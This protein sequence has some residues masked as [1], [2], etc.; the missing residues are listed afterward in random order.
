[1]IKREKKTESSHSAR[2]EERAKEWY[3]IGKENLFI[4][5]NKDPFSF[6]FN[7]LHLFLTASITLIVK[8]QSESP[9]HGA[10]FVMF[11]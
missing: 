8:E 9:P 2:G 6:F 5:R 7:C 11:P 1:M 4:K 10:S 3:Y